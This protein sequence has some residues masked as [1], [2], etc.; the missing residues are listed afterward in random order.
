MT[1]HTNAPKP[2]IQEK[3]LLNEAKYYRLPKAADII[4][5]DADLLLHL[6]TQGKIEIIAPVFN[7]GDY[8]WPGTNIAKKCDLAIP[9]PFI[10]TFDITSRVTIPLK[11]LLEIEA[12]GQ[13][14]ITKF[15]ETEE[16]KL[17]LDAR[18]NYRKNRSPTKF[19]LKPPESIVNKQLKIAFQTPWELINPHTESLHPTTTHDLFVT[20][21][22]ISRLLEQKPV[23]PETEERN[24]TEMTLPKVHGNKTSNEIKNI[25]ILKVAL[26][27]KDKFPEKCTTGADWADMVI[28]KFSNFSGHERKAP[29]EHSTITRLINDCKNP[30]HTRVQK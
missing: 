21:K 13:T 20:H 22:E 28:E 2:S 15:F 17:F 5:C 7:T 14:F 4:G 12:T 30:L 16:C 8:Q 10:S 6:A 25:E 26:Y 11:N 18:D 3:A 19:E 23:E 24:K 9:H 1:P 27:V 29:R